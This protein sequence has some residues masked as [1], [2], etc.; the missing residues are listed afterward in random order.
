MIRFFHNQKIGYFLF[1]FVFF[2]VI[3]TL[4]LMYKSLIVFKKQN[5]ISIKHIENTEN[6]YAISDFQHYNCKDR[7]RKLNININYI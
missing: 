2:L 6:N 4:M 3:Y 7:R 5:E 1:S